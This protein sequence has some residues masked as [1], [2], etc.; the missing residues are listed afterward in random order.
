MLRFRVALLL[1]LGVCKSNASLGKSSSKDKQ[2]NEKEATFRENRFPSVEER[3]KLYMSNWYVPP[4]EDYSEGFVRY[5]FTE[6]GKRW[7]ILTLEGLQN[8]P[9]V[10]ESEN[11]YQVENI[12][13]ADKLFFMNPDIIMNCANQTFEEDLETD[14]RQLELAARVKFRL[15]MKMYCSD[16]ADSVLSALFHVQWETSS[17]DT[18]GDHFPPVLFQFGD[19]KNSHHFGNVMLPHVKKFRSAAT[20]RKN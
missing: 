6:K 14:K 13:D 10:N 7:P 5:K 15:N 12:V 20:S 19:N 1:L 8:H 18:S 9:L 11:T 17:G 2:Q 4:C 16:V 3:V